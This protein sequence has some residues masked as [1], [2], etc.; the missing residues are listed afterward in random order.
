MKSFSILSLRLYLGII[1]K[2]KGLY[3]R[4]YLPHQNISKS[5]RGDTYNPNCKKDYAQTKKNNQMKYKCFLLIKETL[6]TCILGLHIL[7]CNS[8]K[9]NTQPH[10]NTTAKEVSF[11]KL[12]LVWYFG[13]LVPKVFRG[14]FP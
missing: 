14:K 11:V 6:Q 9:A 10:K 5:H 8:S 4:A 2:S 3:P 1:S 7:V 12:F 13:V